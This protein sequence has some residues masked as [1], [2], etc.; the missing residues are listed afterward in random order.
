MARD[1]ELKGTGIHIVKM[2]NYGG[3]ATV[4]LPA[5]VREAV[6]F[7]GGL[8]LGVLAIGPCVVVA[9]ITDITAEGASAEMQRAVRQAYKEWEKQQ[10]KT[11][12]KS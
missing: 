12:K 3:T 11:E 1:T 9:R 6:N 2:N 5:K 4:T 10:N 8:Y 7:L